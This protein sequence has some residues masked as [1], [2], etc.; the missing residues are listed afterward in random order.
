MSELHFASQQKSPKVGCLACCW[1]DIRNLRT[2]QKW[3]RKQSK[4]SRVIEGS[5]SKHSLNWTCLPRSPDQLGR[6]W[7]FELRMKPCFEEWK[8]SDETVLVPGNHRACDECPFAAVC[9]KQPPKN[10]ANKIRI[11]K[12]WGVFHRC[13][14]VESW[15]RE[16]L[17]PWSNM[18][19]RRGELPHFHG[20]VGVRVGGMR[21][22]LPDLVSGP[23]NP[24]S[25]QRERLGRWTCDGHVVGII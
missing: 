14:L 13:F 1:D 23:S 11:I 24:R 2:K 18:L 4:I 21:R 7:Q 17:K 3:R 5:C 6:C 19:D 25:P 15:L 16:R 9:Y 22:E 10:G 20:L 8:N 12:W